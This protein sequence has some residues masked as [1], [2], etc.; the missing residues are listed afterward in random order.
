MISIKIH[1][2]YRIVVAVCDTDLIGKKFEE[3][4]KQLEIKEYFF[5]GDE[6]AEENA[7]KTLEA[8]KREDATFDIVGKES[9]RAA[10]KAGIISKDYIAK[11]KNVPFALVLV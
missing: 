8:Q 6:M 4:K 9:I 5:R 1:R 7:I 11:I 2:S 10:L 3:G